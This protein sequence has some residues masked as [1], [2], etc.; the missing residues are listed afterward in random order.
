V[1]QDDALRGYLYQFLSSELGQ[2]QLKANI[3]GAIVD[4]IEPD[5]V[6]HVLVPIPT[7]REALEKVGL[8]VIRSMELQERAQ[9]ELDASRAALS[10][11]I[12]PLAEEGTA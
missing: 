3:Y 5:E 11:S 6:K 4:H 2:H 1:T 10:A 12:A 9:A 7:N 8:P